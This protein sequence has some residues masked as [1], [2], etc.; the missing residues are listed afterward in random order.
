MAIP[1]SELVNIVPRV[2]AGTGKDLNFNGLF[3][4]HNE[5][6]PIN[7]V[8]DFASASDVAKFFGAKSLETE[9]AT[10]YFNGF[11][12][13]D[14]KPSKLLFFR[15][16]DDAV[17]P[18]LRGTNI[19]KQDEALIAI[20]RINN[21]SFT[22][23]L[24]ELATINNIDFSTATSLSDVAD[25]L[26]SKLRSQVS[27]GFGNASVRYSSLFNAFIVTSGQTGASA[28][29]TYATGSVAEALKLQEG[30]AIKSSGADEN[31]TTNGSLISGE[32]E[33]SAL[34][35]L[36]AI[37]NGGFK[38]LL[39]G[40]ETELSNLNFAKFNT[41]ATS[42][43]LTGK[44]VGNVLDQ[45][46]AI[47]DGSIKFTIDGQ[48]VE[49]TALNFSSAS[50]LS[51]VASAITAKLNSKGTLTYNT[52]HFVLT[53][54]SKGTSS[55][56]TVATNA[57]TGTAIAS[58]L[59]LDAGS[60]PVIINGADEVLP[61]FDNVVTVLQEALADKA[62]VS[63]TG[64][65]L[66]IVSNLQG[67]GSS[68]G[69]ATAGTGTDISS[70][71]KLKQ[72]D[73]ALSLDGVQGDS[74]YQALENATKITQNFVTF[75]TV[76]K[77]TKDDV[78]MMAQWSNAQFNAGNQYLFVYYD[79]DVNLVNG[80]KNDTIANDLINLNV[81]G[82]CGVFGSI[83]YAGFVM[84]MCA[85]IAWDKANS[86]ITLAFKSQSGLGAN[87][88]DR[89]QARAL[90]DKLMNYVGNYATRNDNFIL[91]QKGAM[92]GKWQWIDTYLNSTWLNNA[93]QVQ[94]MAG[95]ESAKRVPYTDRGYSLIR[96]W[97]RDVIAR[98]INN[99]VIDKGVALSETQK[100]LI[101][102]ELGEDISNELYS[103]G[104]YLKVID[105][106]AQTRQQRSSPDC[107]LYYTYGGSV[108]KL[109]LP[110][111]AIV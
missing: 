105:A 40:N 2:I 27:A 88:D 19:G 29:I 42:A 71:L 92:F 11:N 77:A 111:I 23:N 51:D 33:T 48:A 98:A 52:D 97:C 86:T 55:T 83:A 20:K 79:N 12:N 36:K 44:A 62:T 9:G 102:Q 35:T 110:S 89:A 26:Q 109:N 18:F 59:K 91:F 64:K 93:L 65:K 75:S 15:A 58:I 41:Q 67:S 50:S 85:S 90:D 5:N 34:T 66:Y 24:G 101:L 57:G 8:L 100:T 7:E 72:S 76:D 38:I 43:T 21:G 14:V 95:F 37:N 63:F 53:A 69:Y 39:N 99:G 49:C 31:L 70:T 104:Y 94:I 13:S 45:L 46:K 4:T 61:T 30:E 84:G 78:L 28:G 54:K 32:L 56:V 96:S 1:S 17:A 68:V 103:N 25:K 106:T 87:V 74:Y 81:D 80:A 10:H 73:G 47:S 108:Q 107:A 82:T 3:F 16:I 6:V 22:I 60:N